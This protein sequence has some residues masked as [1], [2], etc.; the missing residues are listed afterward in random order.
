MKNFAGFEKLP[1]FA[2]SKENDTLTRRNDIPIPYKQDG[3]MYWK[4]RSK[5]LNNW[6]GKEIRIVNKQVI[7]SR[8]DMVK[9][10]F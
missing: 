9:D 7:L 6:K 8:F 1:T 10:L 4:S 2:S 3:E 5:N